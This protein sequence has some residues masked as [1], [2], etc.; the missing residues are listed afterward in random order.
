MGAVLL[1]RYSRVIAARTPT[2]F[3]SRFLGIVAH[4]ATGVIRSNIPWTGIGAT[5]AGWRSNLPVGPV[6]GVS[7]GWTLC[8]CIRRGRAII[9]RPISW[10]GSWSRCRIR[11]VTSPRHR[12]S[13][14][15]ASNS[16]N[17]GDSGGSGGI[18]ISSISIRHCRISSLPCVTSIS[19]LVPLTWPTKK[20]T[21]SRCQ[22]TNSLRSISFESRL[23]S[24]LGKFKIYICNGSY[25]LRA[26]DH[27]YLLSMGVDA[28][29]T[30]ARQKLRRIYRISR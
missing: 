22:V 23:C 29:L 26:I 19:L 14:A 3:Q 8:G 5:S 6:G 16:S 25:F 28:T 24:R 2:V 9:W 4:A 10:G 30:I 18:N 21:T 15:S 27:R 20:R 12:L 13:R 1:F 17:S 7:P 11:A